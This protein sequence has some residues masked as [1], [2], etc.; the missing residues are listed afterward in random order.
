MTDGMTANFVPPLDHALETLDVACIPFDLAPPETTIREC[1]VGISDQEESGWK[2]VLVKDGDCLF[3]LASQSVV[4][5]E[6]N[7]CWFVGHAG[8]VARRSRIAS[9][10]P[11]SSKNGLK[12]MSPKS[13]LPFFSCRTASSSGL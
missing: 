10:L 4:E 7:K 6:G 2:A 9:S 3:E 5:R 1:G 8:I 11:Q 13:G 12:S